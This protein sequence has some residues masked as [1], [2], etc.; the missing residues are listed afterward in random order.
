MACTQFLLSDVYDITGKDQFL[1]AGA[2]SH[3][4]SV[5]VL[6]FVIRGATC[7]LH[8]HFDPPKILHQTEAWMI[9]DWAVVPSMLIAIMDHPEFLRF[10]LSSLKRITYAGSPLAVERIKEAVKSPCR[11]PSMSY[12]L[13]WL[14]HPC[15]TH[16]A[17][18]AEVLVPSLTCTSQ[19]IA[20][21]NSEL[22]DISNNA[23]VHLR[24]GC[25]ALTNAAYQVC[26]PI[27]KASCVPEGIMCHNLTDLHR[28]FSPH[29]MLHP[30]FLCHA[31]E[32]SYLRW[33][34]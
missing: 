13:L 31:P 14:P 6:P 21:P 2:L 20:D 10:D 19:Y 12:I 9:T 5:R 30:R 33:Q 32:Y 3:A 26:L 24:N 28:S 17:Q 25:V 7:H 16:P 27:L 34:A 11:M 18:G 22:L 23:C 4:G 1:T 29:H 15:H 8:R